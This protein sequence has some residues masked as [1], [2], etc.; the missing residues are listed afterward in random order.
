[1]HLE[2]SAMLLKDELYL[3]SQVFFHRLKYKLHQKTII[4]QFEELAACQEYEILSKQVDEA[5]KLYFEW[6]FLTETT[7][8]GSRLRFDELLDSD[9]N[10]IEFARKY[11]L[12][13]KFKI[14]KALHSIAFQADNKKESAQSGNSDANN[15]SPTQTLRL[16]APRNNYEEHKSA[17]PSNFD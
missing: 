9:R 6:K 2:T 5:K 16:E 3:L 17:R 11:M 15:T 8:Y 4:Q 12:L 7:G 10:K 1:M 14:P 13:D